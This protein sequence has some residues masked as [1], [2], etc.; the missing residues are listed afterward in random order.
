MKERPVLDLSN[1]E[2]IRKQEDLVIY[3]YSNIERKSDHE[4]V[5]QYFYDRFD[6]NDYNFA[7]VILFVGKTGDGKS[8]A[9]NAFFNI[10]KGIKL[11]DKY[12]FMLIEEKEKEKGQATSQTDGVHLYYL[13]DYNNNPIIIIDSQGYGDTRGIQYDEKINEAFRYVFGSVINHINAVGF[14]SKATNNRIDILTKYIFSCVTS[15]FAGDVPIG[16]V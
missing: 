12:R 13:R 2:E 7:Y 9:I 3:R 14:I 1:Y 4:L 15:L 6:L 11:E 16:I 8:T 10:I 5:Y